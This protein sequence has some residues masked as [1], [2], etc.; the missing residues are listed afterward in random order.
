MGGEGRSA[1]SEG[2][3][4]GGRMRRP[5]RVGGGERRGRVGLAEGPG[6]CVN[7]VCEDLW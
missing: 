5:G 3:K 7:C 2:R 6:V 4:E 1:R